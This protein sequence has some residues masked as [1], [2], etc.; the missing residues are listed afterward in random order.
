MSSVYCTLSDLEAA[1]TKRRL[2]E[3]TNDDNPTATGEIDQTKVD[4]AIARAGDLIDG[5]LGKRYSLPLPSVP[6][7][8]S[9]LAVDITVHNLFARVQDGEMSQGVRDREKEAIRVLEL[10]M[11]GEIS[12][13][14]PTT[15]S[16]PAPIVPVAA[17]QRRMFPERR[18]EEMDADIRM[19]W[20]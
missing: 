18:L 6:S 3:A 7:L 15:A 12:L 19:R 14:L 16:A 10:I 2:I 13:G 8:V 4:A 11:R 1:V 9:R 5:Y 20:F 17:P